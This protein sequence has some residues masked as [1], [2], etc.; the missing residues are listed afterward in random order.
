VVREMARTW[1][2]R[3]NGKEDANRAADK[4]KH[5]RRAHRVVGERRIGDRLLT[6]QLFLYVELDLADR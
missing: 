2:K 1:R 5:L 3:K 6:S 4:N